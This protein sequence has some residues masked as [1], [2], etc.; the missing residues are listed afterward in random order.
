MNKIQQMLVNSYTTLVMANK[1]TIEDVID[2]K[3]IGGIEYQI[4]SE[5]EIRI[6]EKT[7]EIIG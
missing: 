1:M 6:A 4:K 7:I 3:T 5:V 2:V